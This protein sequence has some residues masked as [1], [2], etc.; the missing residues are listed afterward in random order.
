MEVTQFFKGRWFKGRR[1]WGRCMKPRIE[2]CFAPKIWWKL[3][4]GHDAQ[5]WPKKHEQ[6]FFNTN[7]TKKNIN[8]NY[9]WLGKEFRTMELNST[10]S[11]IYGLAPNY[12][13]HVAIYKQ[14]ISQ[15]KHKKK[16]SKFIEWIDFTLHNHTKWKITKTHKVVSHSALEHSKTYKSWHTLS[17]EQKCL[18][19]SLNNALFVCRYVIL[20]N[21]KKKKNIV[22]KSC[23]MNLT[24]HHMW[25]KM[26]CV[27]TFQQSTKCT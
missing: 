4:F 12:H 16:S 7:I 27:W 11:W 23:F 1:F 8:N 5:N 26:Q 3:W 20:Q 6:F 24:M 18:N 17:L 15:C 19:M 9:G 21:H 22:D 14:T 2:Q 10:S 25:H 13:L